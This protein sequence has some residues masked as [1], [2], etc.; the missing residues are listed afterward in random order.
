MWPYVVRTISSVLSAENYVG[1]YVELDRDTVR[2]SVTIAESDVLRGYVL[3]EV[4]STGQW[5]QRVAEWIA[6]YW[7]CMLEEVRPIGVSCTGM[8]SLRGM[9]GGENGS[10]V[11]L[12][13]PVRL[14]S[15]MRVVTSAGMSVFPGQDVHVVTNFLLVKLR[16]SMSDPILASCPALVRVSMVY[17][18]F[19]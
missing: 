10:G 9:M 19:R 12:L 11:V 7:C 1:L 6:N 5:E 17:E 16:D 14:E 2:C 15:V 13:D 8:P 3:L 18:I 4:V